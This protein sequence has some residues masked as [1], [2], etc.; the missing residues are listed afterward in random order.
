VTKWHTA[1][2]GEGVSG[3]DQAL[4]AGRPKIVTIDVRGK[5]H[6]EAA[7]YISDQGEIAGNQQL[8]LWRESPLSS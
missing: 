7:D 2:L 3:L 8:P 1:V 5:F 6:G 4:K